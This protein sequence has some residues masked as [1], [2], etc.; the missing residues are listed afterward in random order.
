MLHVGKQRE[1]YRM[2]HNKH[3]SK[4]HETIPLKCHGFREILRK[5]SKIYTVLKEF[6]T[7]ELLPGSIGTFPVVA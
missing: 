6:P 3:T 1:I 4:S 7:H 5:L 2:A